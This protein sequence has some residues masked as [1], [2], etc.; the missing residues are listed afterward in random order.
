MT[1]RN[2]KF[3][4]ETWGTNSLVTDYKPTKKK[5]I[6]EVSTEKFMDEKINEETELFDDWNYGLESFTLNT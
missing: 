5:M 1:D 2:V 4:Q 6:R 3:M